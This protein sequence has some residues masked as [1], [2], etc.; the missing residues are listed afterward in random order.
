MVIENFPRNQTRS[1]TESGDEK[2]LVKKGRSNCAR[3]I[4]GR[5][6][7]CLP[8]W[9]A[10]SGGAGWAKAKQVNPREGI[11]RWLQM[12]GFGLVGRKCPWLVA[13]SL[14]ST[15][16]CWIGLEPKTVISA[17]LGWVGFFPTEK[18]R[19]TVWVSSHPSA[20]QPGKKPTQRFL[21]SKIRSHINIFKF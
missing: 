12:A 14:Q 15:V 20:E 9:S 7:A 19:R 11:Y 17:F 16:A 3:E 4:H 8:E 21:F 10:G 18:G 5:G 13:T 2:W 6:G 1:C